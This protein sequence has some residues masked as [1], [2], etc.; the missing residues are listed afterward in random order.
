MY[1]STEPKNLAREPEF[2]DPLKQKKATYDPLKL[3]KSYKQF[4][5]QK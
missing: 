4:F 5:K 3:Q 1:L 2:K